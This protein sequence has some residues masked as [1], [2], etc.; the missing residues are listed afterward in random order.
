MFRHPWTLLGFQRFKT[1]RFSWL[2]KYWFTVP[3]NDSWSVSFVY[4]FQKL[5]GLYLLNS[6]SFCF[7]NFYWNL[8]GNLRMPIH[9][10][11]IYKLGI[12]SEEAII[13]EE[14][15]RLYNSSLGTVWFHFRV[16]P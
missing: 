15:T 13:L 1:S 7:Q 6:S 10:V 3:G 11:N 5:I 9:M 14:N 12:L 16:S 4:L 2:F 8:K